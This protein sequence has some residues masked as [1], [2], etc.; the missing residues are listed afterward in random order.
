MTEIGKAEQPQLAPSFVQSLKVLEEKIE[1]REER[2]RA[3]I[4]EVV[5]QSIDHV[6]DKKKL[7]CLEI[8]K[9]LLPAVDYILETLTTRD[10]IANEEEI[11]ADIES[12]KL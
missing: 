4:N 7:R 8:Q 12:G 3:H 10:V 1:K 6:L 2:T 9:Y 11:K 5:Y